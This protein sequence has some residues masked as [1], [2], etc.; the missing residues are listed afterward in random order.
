MRSVSLAVLAAASGLALVALWLAVLLGGGTCVPGLQAVAGEETPNPPPVRGERRVDPVELRTK[1]YAPH[2]TLAL[3]GRN[4]GK[5]KPCGCTQPQLGGLERLAALL[6]LLRERAQGALA[7][8]SLGW[9]MPPHNPWPRDQAQNGLK[10][11]LYRAVL[12]ELGFVA[13]VVGPHDIY[14]PELITVFG[15]PEA[16]GI[17]RPCLPLNMRPTAL[18]G[19][20]PELP[21]HSWV[22]FRLRSLAVR[23][24]SVVDEGQGEMLQA[25]GLAQQV[26]PPA[27]A[28]QQAF[29]PNPAQLWIV[30]VDGGSSVVDGVRAAMRAMGPCVIVDMSGGASDADRTRVPL[31]DGPLVVSFDDKGRSIG[32]LDLDPAPDGKGWL[33]T[34]CVQPLSPIFGSPDVPSA[35]RGRVADLFDAYRGQV[36]EQRLVALEARHAEAPGEPRFVGSAACARC[37]EGIYQ[38]WNATPHAKALRTLK[39]EDYAWDPECLTCHVQG[40]RKTKGEGRFSWAASGFVDPD[41]SPHLGAVGCENCHGPGSAHLERPY[42]KEVWRLGGPLRARPAQADCVTCHD[43]DNSVGFPEQYA[44]RRR[45][46][47]HHRVPK[48]RR[49]HEPRR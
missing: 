3:V 21:V 38:D 28:L 41:A 16:G 24:L 17:H 23:A 29:S 15:G 18:A 39:R 45:K 14:V 42:D 1:R 4:F 5:F 40:P 10:A 27:T 7:P 49:T 43:I 35:A 48:E 47:D 46:V 19:V 25:S 44:E 32:V 9:V 6:D 12:Q 34:W 37:H 11:E 30:A 26:I 13:H 36:R 2:V 33:A 22:D 31:A 20:D 8:V